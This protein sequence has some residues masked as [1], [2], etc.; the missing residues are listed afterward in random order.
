MRML[1]IVATRQM[2]PSSPN[3]TR[4]TW[5]RGLKPMF[6]DDKPNLYRSYHLSSEASIEQII[7]ISQVQIS[8]WNCQAIGFV[9]SLRISKAF[10]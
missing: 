10:H 3:P 6:C 1:E 9:L 7:R 5:A 8:M 2:H 4:A